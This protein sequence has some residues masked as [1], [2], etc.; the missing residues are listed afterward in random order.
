MW[1]IIIY[2][3]IIL[4]AFQILQ[5]QNQQKT[6]KNNKKTSYLVL[7]CFFWIFYIFIRSFQIVPHV[8]I[9]HNNIVT[10]QKKNV[11][12]L[13]QKKDFMTCVWGKLCHYSIQNMWC[14]LNGIFT[15]W[16]LLKCYIVLSLKH[17]K[18][19]IVYTCGSY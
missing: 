18:L 4:N 14:L 9:M 15:F 19:N 3:Y 11:I 8:S 12:F 10:R 13:T 2:E 16:K 5:K 17:E 6:N 1:I 7:K